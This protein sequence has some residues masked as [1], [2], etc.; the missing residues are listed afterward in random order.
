MF[1]GGITALMNLKLRSK[2]GKRAGTFFR[3]IDKVESSTPCMR[4]VNLLLIDW[5]Y[6]QSSRGSPFRSAVD[7]WDLVDPR[8]PTSPKNW[9][10]FTRCLRQ[11]G[12]NL[13]WTCV[14]MVAKCDLSPQVPNS[15]FAA[16]LVEKFDWKKKKM[17]VNGI[18]ADIPL[19]PNAKFHSNLRGNSGAF[20]TKVSH[21]NYA[22]TAFSFPLPSQRFN[23]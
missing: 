13:G 5:G 9:M 2:P 10:E 8:E 7:W 22:V 15:E 11:I 23:R 18:E 14:K 3:G 21:L 6:L 19:K 17:E 20:K 16:I 4:L 12:E 1:V